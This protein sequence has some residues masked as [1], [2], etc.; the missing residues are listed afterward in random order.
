MM[1]GLSLGVVS[2]VGFGVL[3]LLLHIILFLF[4]PVVQT[5][6][7]FV[8]KSYHHENIDKSALSDHLKFI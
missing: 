1:N 8:C 5:L 4:G 6:L 3:C 7:Y 2:R